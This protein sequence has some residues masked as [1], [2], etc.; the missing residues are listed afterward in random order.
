[1]QPSKPVLTKSKHNI[2]VAGP[3]LRSIYQ[4]ADNL[5]GIG[6]RAD[7][8]VGTTAH[9]LILWALENIPPTVMR[10][11][12]VKSKVAKELYSHREREVPVVQERMGM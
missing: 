12:L 8:S 2:T 7:I 1:M 11:I 9:A 4:S 3:T 5:L 10:D 6:S